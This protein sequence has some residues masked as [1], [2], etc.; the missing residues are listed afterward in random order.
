MT[1]NE[2]VNLVTFVLKKLW[3]KWDLNTEQLAVWRTALR[4]VNY[5]AA[6]K[7]A[8]EH[9]ISQEGAY[10][11]PKL[12]AII[13]LGRKYQPRQP[14][15]KQPTDYTPSVFV[16]CVEHKDPI[17]LYQFFAVY[18]GIESQNDRDYILQAARRMCERIEA[19]Y[20]G[21]WIIVQ[22]TSVEFMRDMLI[23]YRIGV[24]FRVYKE[25]LAEQRKSKRYEF[26]REPPEFSG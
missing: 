26:I 9:F 6:K 16:Q 21:S 4:P 7:A 15:A 1:D 12:H 14:I 19:L 11:R 10:G 17:K 2:I 25:A 3:P 18:V 20:G 5:F 8:E 22:N 24:D 13:E 23:D